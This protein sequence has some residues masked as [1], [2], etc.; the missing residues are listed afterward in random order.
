MKCILDHALDKVFMIE[1]KSN[2]FYRIKVALNTW[3][4]KKLGT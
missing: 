4:L 3:A 1:D 2:D